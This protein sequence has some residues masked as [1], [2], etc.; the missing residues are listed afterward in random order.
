MVIFWIQ[1]QE[2]GF[3]AGGQIR[4]SLTCISLCGLHPKMPTILQPM[5]RDRQSLRKPSPGPLQTSWTRVSAAAPR[6][7]DVVSC[8]GVLTLAK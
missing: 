1:T 7:K 5:D 8:L 6:R 3:G 4:L 2:E